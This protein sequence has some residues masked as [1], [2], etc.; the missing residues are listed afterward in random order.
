MSLQNDFELVKRKSTQHLS[1]PHLEAPRSPLWRRVWFPRT[2]ADGVGLFWVSWKHE[3]RSSDPRRCTPTPSV[4]RRKPAPSPKRPWTP[5]GRQIHP[6]PWGGF[7]QEPAADI[8][9][10]H[11]G[12]PLC[13]SAYSEPHLLGLRPLP[14]VISESCQLQ[15]R[16]EGGGELRHSQ[17][18]KITERR[19][20]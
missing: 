18:F 14:V 13:S 9:H 8:T 20:Y 7:P 16:A 3:V 19:I 5:S 1:L 11:Q 4:M 10:H 6:Q 17:R 2:P 15:T 12:I